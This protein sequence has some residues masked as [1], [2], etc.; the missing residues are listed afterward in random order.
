MKWTHETKELPESSDGWE[1]AGGCHDG[2]SDG[3]ED[4]LR[5][6]QEEAA[7]RARHPLDVLHPHSRHVRRLRLK[8]RSFDRM[9]WRVAHTHSYLQLNQPTTSSNA[10]KSSRLQFLRSTR[11]AG[12]SELLNA[13][14][15]TSSKA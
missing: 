4:E 9:H 2:E 5:E 7:D 1:V 8:R 15:L 13:G 11:L 14:T 6:T 3:G 12:W 10:A